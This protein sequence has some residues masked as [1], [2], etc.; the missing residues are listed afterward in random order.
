MNYAIVP[1]EIENGG[2]FGPPKKEVS[3]MRHFFNQIGKKFFKF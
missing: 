3:Q 2:L 1:G